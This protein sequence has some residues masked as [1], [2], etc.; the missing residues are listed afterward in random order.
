VEGYGQQLATLNLVPGVRSYGERLI[1][2][3]FGELRVWDPYRSKL[4][5]AIKKGIR[6]LPITTGSRVLYLGAAAEQP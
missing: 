6:T 4:A 1:K 3:D 5:A 2:T